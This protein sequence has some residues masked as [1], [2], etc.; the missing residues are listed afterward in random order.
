M[1]NMARTLHEKH[2]WV[3]TLTLIELCLPMLTLAL[4]TPT[5]TQL[6]QGTFCKLITLSIFFKNHFSCS[7]SSTTCGT[8][9]Q[10]T[11]TSLAYFQILTMIGLKSLSL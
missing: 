10:K 2:W 11:H 4:S 5:Q 9:I 3:Y 8:H 1:N 7:S 6:I